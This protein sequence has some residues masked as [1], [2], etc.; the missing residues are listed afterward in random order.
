MKHSAKLIALLAC[1]AAPV[2]A[3]APDCSGPERYPASEAY[4]YLKNAGVLTPEK[5][6]FAHRKS[7]IVASQR[8]GKDLWRQVFHVTFPLKSGRKVETI[9]VSDASTEEC[10]MSAPQIFLVSKQLN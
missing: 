2:S 1:V 7:R 10:S 4:V 5:V 9:V 6:D 3:K 8:I